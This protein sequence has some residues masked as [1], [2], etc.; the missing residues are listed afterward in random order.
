MS[1]YIPNPLDLR[2]VPLPEALGELRETLA[3]YVHDVWAAGRM[4]EGWTYGPS[5]DDDK[6]EHPN[7]VPYDQLT[8]ADKEFDRATAEATLKLMIAHGWQLLPPME[9]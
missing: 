9:D 1:D 2:H 7:L 3:E 4:A 5:R 6:M 8:E